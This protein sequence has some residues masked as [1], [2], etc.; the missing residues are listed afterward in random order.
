M[1]MLTLKLKPKTIF[2]I[3]LALTGII[4]II[5]TFASNHIEPAESV[6]AQVSASTDEERRDYL[7]SY[8]WETDKDFE[9]KEL[10]VPESWN[11]VYINYNEIQKN[12][13]F[14]LS[15]YKGRKVTLYTY[16]ITNYEGESEGIVADMLVCDGILI[17][18]DVCN[19]A[20]SDGFLTGFSGQ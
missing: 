2:G 8:G 1:K 17:G 9:T 18:G 6:S 12:Q 13:G 4:V 11:D 14:D 19:T 15:D 7:A 20:A 5:I 16:K 10:T 3:I